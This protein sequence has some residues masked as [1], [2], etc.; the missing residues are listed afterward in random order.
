MTSDLLGISISGL[1]YSQSALSTT[2]HN[3]ANAGTQGYSRQNVTGV[4]N[5][6][7]FNG[8]G[9]VGNG[10]A[11][12]SI[13]RM[14]DSFVTQQT[15]TDTS[16]YKDL[17][18]YNS[19]V[20]QLNGLLSDSATGLSVSLTSFF[21]SLQNGADDPTSIPARQLI[22]GE[23]Q[24]LADKFNTL[25]NRFEDIRKGVNNSLD[26]AV[27]KINALTTSLGELN[28]KIAD[29]NGSGAS[30]NDLLDRRDET[31]RELSQ[32]VS[33]RTLEQKD[34][35]VNVVIGNGQSVV[36]GHQVRQLTLAEDGANPTKKDII[37]SGQPPQVITGALD[38]GQLGGLLRFRDGA[39]DTAFSE[40]GR[41]ATVTADMVNRTHQQGITL[42][43]EFGGDFFRDMNSADL[44][45]GRVLGNR[46][47]APPQ[48]R[49]V[50]LYIADSTKLQASNYEVSLEEGGI[51]RITRLSDSKEVAS[52]LLPAGFPATVDF[53]GL[54][55][56]F[57]GGSLQAGDKFLL[58]PVAFSARSF[59][60]EIADP[61][62]IAFGSPLLTDSSIGNIGS[63]AISS[64]QVLSLT[65]V[66]G[67]PLPLLAKQGQMDPP[68]VVRFTSPT[69]YE[70]LDNSDPGNPVHLDPPIRD[71][72]FVPGV[73]NKIF[74]A[75]SGATRV[76]SEGPMM[77]LPD[78]RSATLQASAD[79]GTQKLPNGYPSE[80]IT[81][82]KAPTTSG[83]QPVTQNLFTSL[84]ASARDIAA[85]LSNVA[86]VSANA[87]TYLEITN[88]NL[89]ASAP[90]QIS[91]NG[92][93]VLRH[94]EPTPGVPQLAPEI[95]D[96]V[97][98]PHGFND[99][100]AAQ[101]NG[102]SRF[103]QQGVR[104]VA[105]S[106]PVTGEPELRIYDK[107]G[108]DIQVALESA[109]GD[110]IDVS[111][112]ENSA[113]ALDG[114]GAG[115]A[116]AIAVG[117]HL[118]VDLASGV[119][120]GSH[121]A[122][123]MIFGDTKAAGFAQSSYLGIQAQITGKPET[124]DTFT[125]NFNRDGASD[126]RNALALVRLESAATVNGSASLSQGY[127]ALVEDIGIKTSSSK[128]SRDAAQE[129]LNQTTQLR[130]S[131]SGVNLDEEAANLIRFE[132]MFSANAQVISVARDL[133]DRLINS[134]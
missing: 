55:L 83:G 133:F 114:N 134:F 9:Y 1:R 105:G 120:L 69:T 24:N 122:Q 27:S 18:A 123:S 64:G 17:E 94:I 116:S 76:L 89:D 35:Q 119:T 77:G 10:V 78:G 59:A 21:G 75:D 51:Y 54:E 106:D 14:V 38:G 126:N 115:T 56:V 128:I 124:G 60:T 72:D 81:I 32:L 92:Q 4:T 66:D 12:D 109:V 90:P 25:H 44:A 11:I 121:P 48:D 84:N 74:G 15:R 19:Y 8:V 127:G 3:I 63:G 57:E 16:L 34:G 61:R 31:L 53:E 22:I 26:A 46:N 91:V 112:G 98:D 62:G 42:N 129:V 111:D 97:T 125:I 110:S 2:G 117:G 67:N 93:P 49:Q 40:L 132:Q 102:D 29:A 80:V 33:I 107:D 96:P 52:G 43:N 68:L 87:R 118:D 71:R 36:V 101:I 7:S 99:Y 58:Q 73:A 108:D 85:Q 88:L 82:T 30:P 13:N 104:A 6:P 41:L 86:G 20:G 50:S 23:A 65:D 131:I 95:P 113:V 39:L 37:L 70:V 45:A 5:T 100:V 103:Q 28:G 79:V 130:D 47:N